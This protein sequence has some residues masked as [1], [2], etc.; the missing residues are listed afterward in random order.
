[1]SVEF[2][3]ISI[4][5]LSHNRLWGESA[6]VRTAH[7]TT[8]LV[9]EKGRLILVDPS[10]PPVALA[11]RFSERTGKTLGDVTDVFCTTL[12]LAHRR[13]IEGLPHAKW[14]ACELEL[15]SYR[16]QL[17]NLLDSAGRLSEEDAS[18]ARADIALIERFSLAPDRFSE[19]VSLY[20]TPGPTAGAAGLLLTPPDMTVAVA[21]DAAPTIPHVEAGQ[22]WRGCE[23]ASA[24]MESLRELLEI[25]DV[26]V[27][28]HD[29][30]MVAPRQ[31]WI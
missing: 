14:W 25:A 17:D 27:T 24:A 9:A 28:G 8:T 10:L 16:R 20:P 19:Q 7:A 4:G 3:V 26:I 1:M 31:R 13:G 15:L 21:G 23:D 22:V 6:A 18:S 29:N 12:R 11:A 30:L 2:T 5:T